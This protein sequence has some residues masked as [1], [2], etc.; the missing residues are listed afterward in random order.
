MSSRKQKERP[1]IYNLL[2][3]GVGGQGVIS[4]SN[5]I[6]WAALRD[7]YKVRT[8]ETHGM[9]QR[10]GSVSAFLRFGDKVEGPL[11]PRGSVNAILSFELVEAL[12]NIDFANS[13]TRFIISTNIQISPTVL[14]G[15]KIKVDYDKC[16]GCGNCIQ[17]CYPH[18]L[19]EIK[20]P[21]Y[22]YI[23]KSPV[24]IYKGKRGEINL[25]TGCAQCI[26]QKACA[27]DALSLERTLY[28]PTVR[29]VF[30]NIKKISKYIYILN[31]PDLALK[32]GNP[33]T[34][35]TVM[36]GFLS[37][38]NILPIDEDILFNTLI[39]MVPQKAV[40]NNKKAYELGKNAALSYDENEIL[41]KYEYQDKTIAKTNPIKEGTK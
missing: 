22:T 8:A 15:R 34:Q 25:C 30:E 27:F 9:A 4:A 21:E 20:L 7:H 10:G 12:R 28:Y 1:D 6:A 32:A 38:L 40:E 3:V 11:I 39:S 33:R 31:A 29:E 41:K 14:I 24:Y 23:P 17:I 37:G 35:N 16:I 36:I 5:I 18:Y 13:E 2:T 26:Y 19:K